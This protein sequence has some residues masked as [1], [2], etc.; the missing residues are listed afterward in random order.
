MHHY[1]FHIQIEKPF[2]NLTLSDHV[3]LILQ[4]SD[5]KL[6]VSR[7][8][9]YP[10][11]IWR[12]IGGKPNKKETLEETARRELHEETKLNIEPKRIHYSAAIRG[13]ATDANGE[14]YALTTHLFWV[15]LTKNEHPQASDDID[16]IQLVTPEEFQTIIENYRQLSPNSWIYKNGHKKFTWYDYGQYYAEIHQ[17]AL[18]TVTA[19]LDPSTM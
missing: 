7:K 17:I 6:L 19:I 8:D 14:E 13:E 5:G 2:S 12:L 1:S 3:L 16:E 10:P 15:K 18:Q 9:S 11:H 4:A